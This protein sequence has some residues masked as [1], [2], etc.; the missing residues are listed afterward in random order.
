[1]K[2]RNILLYP[3]SILYG[4]ITGFRNFLYKSEML[5]STEF[6]LPVICI[7]NITV[8]GTGKTPHTEYL[9]ALLSKEFRVA[10][11]LRI[12]RNNVTALEGGTSGAVTGVP[13][14]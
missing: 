11:G 7:G 8:G 9:A 2:T 14:G 10:V 5:K 4:L 6:G 1:M 3:F 12:S 13:A